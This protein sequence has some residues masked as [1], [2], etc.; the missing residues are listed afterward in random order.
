MIGQ[1]AGTFLVVAA[2]VLLRD[3][4]LMYSALLAFQ[5]LLFPAMGWQTFAVGIVALSSIY[6]SHDLVLGDEKAFFVRVDR[7]LRSTTW[8]MLVLVTVGYVFQA[9]LSLVRQDFMGSWDIAQKAFP[10]ILVVLVY[11]VVEVHADG[12]MFDNGV[13]AFEYGRTILEY[14]VKYTQ[15]GANALF[16]RGQR[17]RG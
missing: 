12:T 17:R 5:V 13:V 15:M 16:S 10:I 14:S 3:P 1:A 7:A 11:H 9:A 4:V 6:M 8:F 2:L